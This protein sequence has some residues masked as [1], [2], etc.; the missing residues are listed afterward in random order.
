MADS[1]QMGYQQQRAVL[2]EQ[3]TQFV[4]LSLWYVLWSYESESMS[5]LM[6]VCDEILVVIIKVIGNDGYVCTT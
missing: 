2:N 6:S 1:V 4:L 5:K 3:H